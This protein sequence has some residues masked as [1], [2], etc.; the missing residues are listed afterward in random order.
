MAT[1]ESIKLEGLNNVKEM[2]AALGPG[3]EAANER[4]QNKMAYELMLAE[5][6][7]AKA[8]LDRPTSFTISSIVY[9]KRLQTKKN[10]YDIAK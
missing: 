3:L 9:K 5:R 6:E 8:K 1:A 2:L 10:Y 7:H 4:A